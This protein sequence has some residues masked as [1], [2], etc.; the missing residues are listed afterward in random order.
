MSILQRDKIKEVAERGGDLGSKIYELELEI[1]HQTG[2]V[3]NEALAYNP[4]EE[5][6]AIRSM[7]IRHFGMGN[8][9]MYTPRLEFNDLAVINRDQAD[10]A[11]FNTYQPNDGNPVAGDQINGWRSNAIRPVVRNKCISIGAHATARLMFP[12]IFAYDKQS[13]HQQEAG[14][15]LMDLME[16][17]AEQSNYAYTSLQATIQA[18]VSPACFVH[19][20]YSE[21]YR[22]V[23][24]EQLPDGTYKKEWILDTDH[25]GFQ[26]NIIPVDQLFIENIY[27]PEIQK[28]GW[29]LWRRVQSYSLLEAKYKNKYSNWKYVTPGVQVIYNDANQTFY[30]VYDTNMRSY[31]CEEIVYWNRN[32]DLMIIMVNGIM[33]TSHDNPNP[34]RD[35]LY[36]IAK[37]GYE[38][39]NPKFFYYKSLAFKVSHD[40]NIVNTLYPMIIDGTYLNL[41]PPMI[42]NGGETIANDVIVPGAVTTLSDPNASLTP[43]KLATDLRSGFDS[44]MKVEESLNQ[45]SEIPIENQG[46]DQTA[47]EISKKEQE[48]NTVLGMFM[49]MIGQFVKQYGR[50]RVGDIMQYLTVAD[51]D[52]I[53]DDPELVYKTFLLHNKKSNGK[54]TTRKIKF[55]KTL[56]SE[57]L[58]KEQELEHSYATLKAQGGHKSDVELY[59]VNPELM[60]DL[61]Y[62]VTVSPDVLNPM[63]EEVE[64]AFALEEYDRAIAN[65]FADQEAV[66]K[67]LLLS[68]YPRTAKDPDKYLKK[69]QNNGM[70]GQAQQMAQSG[71]QPNM[72]PSQAL[73]Q[74]QMMAGIKP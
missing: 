68:I 67:D 28:Q 37:F 24:R 31:M 41:M 25:S 14:Q 1:D 50:L 13:E 57:P 73:A 19:T 17:S 2:I 54:N 34:R 5:E 22:E 29:L 45:T 48:R 43:V 26:D 10:Q 60:R 66:F 52:K 3:K 62:M 12:K 47:Y 39:I 42:N 32:M 46:G 9:T 61:Q 72:Q 65:P 55:D 7:I 69:D 23:K 71:G 49:Q 30:S 35:K 63:S 38:L 11:S 6:R 20:E 70:L 44:L 51:V 53:T 4:S 18:E 36:P 58:T 27:E 33:L 16:W 8:L 15:V 74:P 56:T 64:R 21:T 40:A 59:R